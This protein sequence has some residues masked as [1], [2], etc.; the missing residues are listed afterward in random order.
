MMKAWTLHVCAMADTPALA[1]VLVSLNMHWACSK[2]QICMRRSSCCW[3]LKV[4]VCVGE[5][6]GPGGEGG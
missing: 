5:G 1:V 3:L 2:L 4:P 6:A